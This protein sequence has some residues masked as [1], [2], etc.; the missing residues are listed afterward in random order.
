MTCVYRKKFFFFSIL[1]SYL[2]YC[3][4]ILTSYHTLCRHLM[5]EYLIKKLKKINITNEYNNYGYDLHIVY[6]NVN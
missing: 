3:W 4:A 2:S 5:F 1:G 6:T